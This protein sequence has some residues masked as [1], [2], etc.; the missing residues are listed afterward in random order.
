MDHLASDSARQRPLLIGAAACALVVV[1][2]IVIATILGDLPEALWFF[3][4][5][6]GIFGGGVACATCLALAGARRFGRSGLQRT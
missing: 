5:P 3:L 2:S 4:V 6:I 1:T